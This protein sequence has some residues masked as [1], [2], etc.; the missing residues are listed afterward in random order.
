MLDEMK[1]KST[2]APPTL[3][4]TRTQQQQTLEI[5]PIPNGI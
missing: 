5:I 4:P 2:I 3:P 1:A